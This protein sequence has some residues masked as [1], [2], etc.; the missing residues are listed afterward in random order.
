MPWTNSSELLGRI[1]VRRNVGGLIKVYLE[2]VDAVA[3]T[4]LLHSVIE[5]VIP[6]LQRT[7]PIFQYPHLRLGVFRGRILLFSPPILLDDPAFLHTSRPLCFL[8][9][10]P[11]PRCPHTILSWVNDQ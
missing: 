7:L 1:H 6:L 10:S 11:K 4:L 5:I 2:T 8:P 3:M 9:F